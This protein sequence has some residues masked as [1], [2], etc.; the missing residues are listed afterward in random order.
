MIPLRPM[1]AALIVSLIFIAPP[2]S[3][4]A[5]AARAKTKPASP[6]KAKGKGETPPR[7]RFKTALRSF[8][9]KNEEARVVMKII[10]PDGSTKDRELALRRVG[11][12]QE[13]RI[14]VRIVAPPDLKGMS[15]LSVVEKN[16][17][18]QWIY[19]PSTKQ[20]RKIVTADQSEGGILGSELKYEDF[21]PAIIRRTT[22]ELVRTEK[23][24]DKT[25]D[26]IEAKLPEDSKAYD[27]VQ[28]LI[29]NSQDIPLGMTY[30]IKGEKIKTVEFQDFKRVG[31]V[32]RP[33]V[34]VIR[35]LKTNRGTD[36]AISG[37]KVNFGLKPEQVT[38]QQISRPW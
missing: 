18:N 6:P 7:E 32:L 11:A 36:I 5:Q 34:I 38:L 23:C 3:A 2:P 24:G 31:K 12:Q 4:Q 10:E 20:T 29:E 22:A 17:E 35:N 16:T 37:L 14:L 8:E 26:L 9:S 1:L 13:Q 25:C 21:D 28:V 27:K 33:H 19:F 30:F 15:L